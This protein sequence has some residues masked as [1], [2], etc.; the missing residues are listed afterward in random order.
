M[1]L[2]ALVAIYRGRGWA[3]FWGQQRVGVMGLTA[4][5]VDEVKC[6]GFAA[7]E[8]MPCERYDGYLWRRVSNYESLMIILLRWWF[9]AFEAGGA[10]WVTATRG[11]V[12]GCGAARGQPRDGGRAHVPPCLDGNTIAILQLGHCS[13]VRVHLPFVMPADAFILVTP[14]PGNRG[15]RQAGADAFSVRI[16]AQ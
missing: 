1:A 7:V 15:G 14:V 10:A 11:D 4:V 12:R 2:A 8:T 9:T 3:I 13:R 5:D 6:T 16:A